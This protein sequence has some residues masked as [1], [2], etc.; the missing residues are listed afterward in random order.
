MTLPE[1]AS[2]DAPFALSVGTKDGGQ[3]PNAADALPV[4]AATTMT[5]RAAALS[6]DLRTDTSVQDRCRVPS[7]LVMMRTSLSHT[8][9]DALH[10]FVADWSESHICDGGN[11]YDT[12]ERR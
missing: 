5:G 8:Q 7:R 12:R 4:Y 2:E 10:R 1:P 6:A 3:K 11:W 9:G